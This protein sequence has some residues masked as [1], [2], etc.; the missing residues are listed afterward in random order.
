MSYDKVRII[1]ILEVLMLT[2]QRKAILDVINSYP[3]HMTAEE[4]YLKA[5]Q[6]MPTIAIGTVYRNLG[7][8]VDAGQIRRITIPD[9]PDRYD[10][11]TKPHEHLICKKCGEVHDVFITGLKDYLER[12]AGIEIT[13]YNL[14]L[15]YICEK[16]KEEGSNEQV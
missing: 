5:K 3:G 13:G 10:R 4:I 8:M 7:V 12:Q 9:S 16:C 2:R 6:K 1:L 14:N 11:S 15:E